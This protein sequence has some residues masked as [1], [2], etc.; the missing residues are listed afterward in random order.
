MT[1]PCE[2]GGTLITFTLFRQY[3]AKFDLLRN[4]GATMKSMKELGFSNYGIT[5]DGRVYSHIS[6]KFLRNSM[7]TSGYEKANIYND[8]GDRK[9]QSIHRSVAMLYVPN[10]ENKPFVNHID[11]NKLN[12]HYTNLEWVTSNENLQSWHDN[13]SDKHSSIKEYTVVP[14]DTEIL[15]DNPQMGGKYFTEDSVRNICE[16]YQKGY[17]KV[18]IHKMTGFK[19]SSVG[20]LLLGYHKIWN[21]IVDQ[22]ETT[23][24]YRVNKLDSEKVIEICENL[25][26]GKGV[27]EVSRL[28]NICRSTVGIIKNR[29][30]YKKISENYLW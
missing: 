17:R 1:K 29:K 22:Y 15:K 21:H 6:K 25:A 13:N 12:N 5:E 10:P 18:D 8:E 26:S 9:N 7:M 11:E 2:F 28:T 30:A 20:N 27:M 3:Q 24:I 19:L 23:H 14:K 4:T 16:L